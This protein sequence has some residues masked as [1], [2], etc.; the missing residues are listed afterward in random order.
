MRLLCVRSLHMMVFWPAGNS[1]RA[2]KMCKG[3]KTAA[4][5]HPSHTQTI[6]CVETRIWCLW[7]AI[8]RLWREKINM[9]ED[10]VL[11]RVSSSCFWFV[12]M[13]L[14]HAA[15]I[16]HS[17]R[18]RVRLEAGR[19]QS[20]QRSR[21]AYLVRTRVRMAAFTHAQMNRTNRATAPGFVLIQPNM[22]SVNA[23]LSLL[24]F[25]WRVGFWRPGVRL[26]TNLYI[27]IWRLPYYIVCERQYVNWV[28]CPNMQYS[29]KSRQKIPGLPCC[30]DQDTTLIL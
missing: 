13:A 20:F 25:L 30:F 9:R 24:T 28:L 27:Q 16:Y 15:F 22:P 19:D 26:M 3:V 8:L 21:S 6:C 2:Y 18:T 23:S 17:N 29:L 5:I 1:W 10:S 11:F 14:V 12:Y 4:G 7:W